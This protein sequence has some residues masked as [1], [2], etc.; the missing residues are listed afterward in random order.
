MGG[1]EKVGP[2]KQ[3]EKKG[4]YLLLQQMHTPT[5]TICVSF[6]PIFVG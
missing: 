3:V 2:V 4:F 5:L 1:L 6:S